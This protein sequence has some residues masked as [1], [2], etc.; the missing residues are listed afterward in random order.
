MKEAK[1]T[2]YVGTDR[3]GL[4]T[5]SVTHEGLSLTETLGVLSLTTNK[6]IRDAETESQK[7][8]GN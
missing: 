3:E 2:I 1:I 8:Q 4:F 7:G 6:L 5:L